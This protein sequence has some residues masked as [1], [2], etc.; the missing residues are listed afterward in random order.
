MNKITGRNVPT[1]I[2]LAEKLASPTDQALDQKPEFQ[3][4]VEFI[5]NTLRSSP[6]PVMIVTIGSVRD[7]V[8]AYN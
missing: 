8:A 4:G 7:V 1:V 6:S 3:K 5:L 2:G